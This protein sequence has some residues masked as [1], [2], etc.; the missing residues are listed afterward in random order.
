METISIIVPVYN[1]EATLDGCL[2]SIL[3]QT[4]RELEIILVN[5]GS[6]DSSLAICN[7][8]SLMDN[9]I[10]LPSFRNQG[11]SKT[12]NKRFGIVSEIVLS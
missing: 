12:R 7:K 5:D 4:Y 8:Y 3:S 6:K 11:V 9:R 1:A 10:E 2:S